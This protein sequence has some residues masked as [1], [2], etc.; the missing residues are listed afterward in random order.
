MKF[1]LSVASKVEVVMTAELPAAPVVNVP[2][3][4][5]AVPLEL[6]AFSVNKCATPP[7]VTVI[8]VGT[9]VPD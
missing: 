2:T 6:F 8:P 3:A 9:P 5:A 1:N 4:T 7:R